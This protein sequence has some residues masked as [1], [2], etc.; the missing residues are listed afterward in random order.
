[1][2]SRK[3]KFFGHLRGAALVLLVFFLL[4]N[5]IQTQEVGVD[6]P[7]MDYKSFDLRTADPEQC[8]KACDDDPKCMAWTYVKPG[9][10]GRNASCWLKSDLPAPVRDDCCI[11]GKK[12]II[13][14]PIPGPF[15][16]N[17]PEILE[18][19]PKDSDGLPFA[20]TGQTLKITGKNFSP[21]P[22]KNKI[23]IGKGKTDG[24]L[25]TIDLIAE[26]QVTKASAERIEGTVTVSLPRD[27]YLVW[28]RV[29]GGGESNP[30]TVWFGPQI[31]PSPIKPAI[32][33]VDPAYP[34]MTTIIHGEKFETLMQVFWSNGSSDLVKSLNNS[35]IKAQ[36]PCGL[37]PGT[38][39][40]WLKPGPGALWVGGS[41]TSNIFNFTVLTP[42]DLNLF[43]TELDINGFA[44]N[45]KWGWQLTRSFNSPDYYPHPA[46]LARNISYKDPQ[47]LTTWSDT[48]ERVTADFAFHTYWE[49]TWRRLTDH[50]LFY[51]SSI[52][53]GQHINLLPATY[54]GNL[55]FLDHAFWDD[56][57]NFYLFHRTGNGSTAC[58]EKGGITVE[59]HSDETI[60]H[61]S[62]PWWVKFHQAVDA[63][64]NYVKAKDM[65]K[66]KFAIITGLVGFDC[67]HGCKAELH[68]V[69]AMAIRAEESSYNE[70]WATFVI[71]EG[72]E[73]F[74]A[75]QQWL[76]TPT[77]ENGS[78]VYRFR[79]PWKPGASSV[80]LT[81]NDFLSLED[82]W[83][84]VTP[85][86]NQGVIV[87]FS[88]RLCH[89]FR[90]RR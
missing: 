10:R 8:R 1:M 84:D 82:A 50:E 36:V 81:A 88:L 2:K 47:A 85:I 66:N 24:L 87:T 11:S 21:V 89:L 80:Q 38:H 9:F 48:C 28:V 59:T 7:G 5:G 33:K 79:L 34:C 55:I 40:V 45:P 76:L 67:A 77:F 69:W 39:A 4:A 29:E 52:W 75:S 70:K 90:L 26:L 3:K 15:K 44:L 49:E 17:P 51:D 64:D 22:A 35:Q 19:E 86:P 60:D 58:Q 53:C 25:H 61:F 31:P 78:Q 74:C 54:E 62:T 30:V 14:Q 16:F 6:L 42:K 71:T 13:V 43:W 73:G 63:G 37:K 20:F 56:D 83:V 41:G 68:P 32:T 57:Y 27:S 12:P 18:V 72:D 46:K 65:L 23:V